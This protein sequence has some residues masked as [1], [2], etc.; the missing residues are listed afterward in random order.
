M[1]SLY[2]ENPYLPKG[3]VI[4]PPKTLPLVVFLGHAGTSHIPAI[5]M[6]DE[7]KKHVDVGVLLGQSAVLSHD[8]IDAALADASWLIIEPCAGS[9]VSEHSVARAEAH[10]IELAVHNP[11][12]RLA[13]LVGNPLCAHPLYMQAVIDRVEYV[14]TLGVTMDHAYSNA[15]LIDLLYLP[16]AIR[17]LIDFH[18]K[19]RARERFPGNVSEL[20]RLLTLP[21]SGT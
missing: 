20:G 10:A 3:T 9:M 18:N 17:V 6:R 16:P 11:A 4:V 12:L 7:L 14:V 1:P 13:M 21:P 19:E 8:E 2:N 5:N 15:K